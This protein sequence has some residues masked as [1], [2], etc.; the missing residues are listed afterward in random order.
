M[1]THSTH[2]YSVLSFKCCRNRSDDTLCG[3][4]SDIIVR[5]NRSLFSRFDFKIDGVPLAAGRLYTHYVQPIFI[6]IYY[7]QF[8]NSGGWGGGGGDRHIFFFSIIYYSFFNPWL[9]SSFPWLITILKNKF[10]L[11]TKCNI[12]LL[13]FN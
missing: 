12:S 9:F 1:T 10:V 3:N 5:P 6:T 8:I 4:L 13:H 11:L 2:F 7:F